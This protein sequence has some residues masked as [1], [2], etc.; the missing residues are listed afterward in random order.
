MSIF[1][2]TL[3]D[4]AMTLAL[5]GVGI[6]A[7]A[8]PAIPEPIRVTQTDGSVITLCMHGDE[9]GFV[10]VTPDNLPVVKNS[11]G[12]Y[13]YANPWDTSKC[14]GMR[15]SDIDMRTPA[16]KTW[17]ATSGILSAPA[18]A[19]RNEVVSTRKMPH[20]PA[21]VK[22]SD[23]PTI[24]RQKALV[25][26]VEFADRQFSTM[27][28]AWSYY[29]G[30]LN[31]PGF[32]YKNGA[33]GSAR[34]F[35][36]D[37]SGGLFDPDFV[38]IGPVQLPGTVDFY[39]ADTDNKLDPNA[40][41]MIVDACNA[42]D[43]E[44]DFS[45]FDAD[46]DGAVD[47]IYFFYA[48]F[49]EAD[50][51][52]GEVIWPHNGLLR[53][54][55]GVDL[56]L[57]GKIINNYACSNEIR[58]NSAPTWLPVG[59][60]T[61]VHEFGH[62]LGIADHYDTRYSSGRIGVEQWDTMAA[63]SYNNNQNTPPA[64]STF[65]RAELG[66]MELTEVDPLQEGV[67]SVPVLTGEDPH[68]LVVRV[69]DDATDEYFIIERRNKTGWDST[70]PAEGV[71]VWHIDMVE[72]L[73]KT[74]DINID[75]VHQHIDIVEADGTENATS[76]HSDVFPGTGKVTTFDFNAWSGEKLFS[77]DHVEQLPDETLLILGGT[78]FIPTT[79][80][81]TAHDVHG[82]SFIVAW[83]P[84]NDAL[85]YVLSVYDT[86]G[87]PVGDF[88]EVL[89][90]EVTEI[91]V[92]GLSPMSEYTVK[93]TA[94]AGSYRSEAAT[95]TVNTGSLEFFESTPLNLAVTNY[96]DG[97]FETSWEN[98]PDATDYEV[99]LYR[100]E[101]SEPVI[102]SYG[103]DDGVAGMP[104][105]WSTN[106][107]KM[108]KPV[109]GEKSPALQLAKDGDWIEFI[110]PGSEIASL[111][112]YQFSQ[113]DSNMIKIEAFNNENELVMESSVQVS[114]EGTIESIMIP[115]AERVRI[116]FERSGG[117]VVIDD[118]E[119]GVRSLE[120]IPCEPYVSV[121]TSGQTSLIIENLD[122]DVEYAFT[123]TGFN[124]VEKS[125]T[126]EMLRFIPS[127]LV[128]GIDAVGASDNIIEE[129]FDLSGHKVVSDQLPAGVY[130][131]R[132]GTKATKVMI[133]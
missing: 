63:A 30:M 40:W 102:H 47:S 100:M 99:T 101:F 75:P 109:F 84:N 5:L 52:R 45:E 65:E 123:V 108:S 118:I 83:D 106:S 41:Q 114:S 29:N 7:Y 115:D 129:W 132:K 91:E 113:L 33:D 60:G 88:G 121:P 13:E 105:G 6:E 61:F 133:E 110:Y 51:S 14:S 35:Y 22:I 64:F 131:I 96:G 36:L 104:E 67:L 49:G 57:D 128:V 48:G 59:I 15:V 44:V 111:A 95:L 23:Y 117:Y 66:W 68:A 34:D 4:V 21:K 8:I 46:N 93:V 74:N 17:I 20:G 31:Q 43:D 10:I 112:F 26:L 38:V 125:R 87:E 97:R 54:N 16:E 9:S 94:I 37:S 58:F 80:E 107:S 124:G 12:I 79:P 81:V 69:P 3:S 19:I 25:V 98:L 73:W 126:S 2:N 77:F 119:I 55:W 120:G 127:T 76:Y 62:V 39:G 90:N 122:D 72:K 89:M 32:T 53:D 78:N 1:R 70:L 56:E 86:L 85:G 28:D 50:S 18:R 92:S 82:T 27:E 24:G 130:I 71:L 11:V 116:T 103:F 42:I